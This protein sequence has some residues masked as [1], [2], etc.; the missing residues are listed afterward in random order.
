[1]KPRNE[2]LM[3]LN[4]DRLFN[5]YSSDGDGLTLEEFQRLSTIFGR[6][7]DGVI[8]EGGIK[9]LFNKVNRNG[10]IQVPEFRTTVNDWNSQ[11][12]RESEDLEVLTGTVYP[13]VRPN[14]QYEV[15][16]PA[17]GTIYRKIKFTN[18]DDIDKALDV[19][20]DNSRLIELRTTCLSLRARTGVDYIRLKLIGPLVLN[21][22]DVRIYLT[23]QNRK[24]VEECLL[25]VITV[26]APDRFTDQIS[27][28]DG[29]VRVQARE[30][31]PPAYYSRTPEDKRAQIANSWISRTKAT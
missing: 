21:T 27:A 14:K 19:T 1:M 28:D 17:G 23:H 31:E 6:Y 24:D 9:A 13:S 7:S 26:I 30:S 12:I 4:L 20:T 16:V 22:Y 11:Y 25:F 18:P 10:K 5:Q 2:E 29:P 8:A 3:N 15:K